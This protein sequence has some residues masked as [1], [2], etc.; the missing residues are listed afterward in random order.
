MEHRHYIRQR[1]L[2]ALK[3]L[4]DNKVIGITRSLE[5][6]D[7]GLTIVDPMIHLKKTCL[8]RLSLTTL[9]YSYAM[10]EMSLP[11]SSI[12]PAPLLDSCLVM[13]NA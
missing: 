2:V 10:M 9:V 12:Q 4:F 7:G 6:S 1:L 11:W 5:I 3:L 8:S 13:I